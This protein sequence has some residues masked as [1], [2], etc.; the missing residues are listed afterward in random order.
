MDARLSR[1]AIDRQTDPPDWN[2]Y[3]HYRTIH[4]KRLEEHFFVDE[5][6]PNT[7]EFEFVE[8]HD[9]LLLH[10]VGHCYCARGVTL[11]VEKWF[12]TRVRGSML[13]VCGVIYRYVAWV[14]GGHLILKYHNVHENPDEYHHR[15]YDISSGDEIL[16][17]KLAR[18][19]F[20]TFTDVLDEIELLTRSVADS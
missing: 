1:A 12:D 14:R 6:N 9:Q 18:F 2:S 13:Q 11:E 8:V 19:Q 10:M 3:D 15:A 16:Y 5:S 7:I 17:E 20:P 4:E